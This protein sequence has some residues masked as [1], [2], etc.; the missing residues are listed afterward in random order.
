M[1]SQKM[2]IKLLKYTGITA[3]HHPSS[4]PQAWYELRYK[5]ASKVGFLCKVAKMD[6]RMHCWIG[7]GVSQRQPYKRVQ[8]AARAKTRWSVSAF[9]ILSC[10]GRSKRRSLEGCIGRFVQRVRLRGWGCSNLAS[11]ICGWFTVTWWGF[12]GKSVGAE[13]H[14]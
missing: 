1:R 11:P 6:Q 3:C 7:I 5:Y 2:I 13:I 4:S 12:C 8:V 9:S 10:S 14:P